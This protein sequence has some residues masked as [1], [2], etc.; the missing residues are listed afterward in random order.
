MGDGAPCGRDSVGDHK[1]RPYTRTAR[2]RGPRRGDPR[3]CPSRIQHGL[4]SFVRGGVP[5]PCG[6]PYRPERGHRKTGMGDGAPCGRDSVAPTRTTRRRGPRRGDPRGRPSRI[7]HGLVSF[8]RGGVPRPCGVPYRPE[9][10]HRK[11]GMGDGAPCG[12]DSVA[13]TRTTRR[14]GPRR[15][16]PRGRPSR[17]QHG[18]VS[19]VRGGVPRPCGRRLDR[20]GKEYPQKSGCTASRTPVL[21]PNGRNDAVRTSIQLDGTNDGTSRRVWTDSKRNSG[22]IGMHAPSLCFRLILFRSGQLHREPGQRPVGLNPRLRI[23]RSP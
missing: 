19:F 14:R 1:G 12:R 8:V 4:V 15:G 3:G 22:Q 9:R 7:Q 10:G 17:I 18:L 6:V 23:L 16:D 2:R 11:T 13:P 21:P 5:R 20:L